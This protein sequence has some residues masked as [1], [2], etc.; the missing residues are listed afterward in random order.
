[1]HAGIGV[2]NNPAENAIRPLALGRKNWLFVG[3]EQAG[4]RAAVLMSL[5]E[6][7][8]LNGHDAWAYL[9]DILTK[10][11]TWPNSRLAELLPHRWTPPL[12]A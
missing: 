1:S 8:K 9:K 10:L 4:E 11:P 5:I 7:A 12:Q 6:S 2:D 3:S